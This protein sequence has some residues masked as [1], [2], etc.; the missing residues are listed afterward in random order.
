MLITPKTEGIIEKTRK[1]KD[2]KNYTKDSENT[3]GVTEIGIELLDDEAEAPRDLVKHGV[4]E[5]PVRLRRNLLLRVLHRHLQLQQ[6]VH[7]VRVPQHRPQTPHYLFNL[8][9]H[10]SNPDLRPKKLKNINQSTENW[11]RS[12]VPVAD[13][14]GGAREGWWW[15]WWKERERERNGGGRGGGEPVRWFLEEVWGVCIYCECIGWLKY[16]YIFF[17]DGG[18]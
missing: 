17:G 14:E 2:R 7:V 11:N 1:K 9:N 8:K 4:T 16:L 18:N 6:R 10:Q 13:R 3:H 12:F 15:W 5:G